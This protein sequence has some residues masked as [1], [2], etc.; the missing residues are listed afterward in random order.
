M[1]APSRRQCPTVVHRP[2]LPTLSRVHHAPPPARL[3]ILRL[4]GRC[5]GDAPCL[6]VPSAPAPSRSHDDREHQ[7]VWPD[8]GG[9][10]PAAQ[11]QTSAS[12][13]R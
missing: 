11:S 6:W 2:L 9:R 7:P 10:P 4:I 5:P 12:A 3:S 8:P 13:A 1:T